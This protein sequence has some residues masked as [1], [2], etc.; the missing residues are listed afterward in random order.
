MNTEADKQTDSIDELEI[1]HVR[2]ILGYFGLMNECTS[3]GKKEF[4]EI[5]EKYVI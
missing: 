2:E 1:Y 5:F 3:F 4:F